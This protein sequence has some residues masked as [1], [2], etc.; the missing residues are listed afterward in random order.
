LPVYR[1]DLM[2]SWGGDYPQVGNQTVYY[3]SDGTTAYVSYPQNQPVTPTP[4]EPPPPPSNWFVAPERTVEAFNGTAQL[5]ESG[6]TQAAA[7]AAANGTRKAPT[8][9]DS[10]S[11]ST[12]WVLYGVLAAGAVIVIV[13][14]VLFIRRNSGH[15]AAAD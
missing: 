2:G 5:I 15:V 13:G 4:T 6:G 9:N 14:A 10:S 7:A 1:V 11:S 12:P 8:S 3:A